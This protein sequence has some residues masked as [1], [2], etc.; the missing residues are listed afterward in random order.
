MAIRILLVDD[1]SEFIEI[2]SEL[3]VDEGFLVE[4]VSNSNEAIEKI[5]QGHFDLLVSDLTMPCGG[6][7]NLVKQSKS[8]GVNLPPLIVL[9]GHAQDEVMEDIQIPYREIIQK[10]VS[11]SKLCQHLQAYV[12]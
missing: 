3:L 8:R 6:L 9:S 1:E 11:G 12:K 5:S 4:G 2:Y 7:R 10:P